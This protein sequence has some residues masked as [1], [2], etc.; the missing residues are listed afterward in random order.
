MPMMRF[1]S[2]GFGASS[3]ETRTLAYAEDVADPYTT[4]GF[5]D[6]M[7]N[8][9]DVTLTSAD[10][11]K[12]II[13]S[14]GGKNIIKCSIT[15]PSAK[16]SNGQCIRIA[17]TDVSTIR[18]FNIIDPDGTNIF[19]NV[20]HTNLNYISTLPTSTCS[21]TGARS[22]CI[23]AT[24]TGM[25]IDMYSNGSIWMV[26]IM[27]A[28]SIDNLIQL[29]VHAFGT[30]ATTPACLLYRC[31]MT[32]TMGGT[33]RRAYMHRFMST[34]VQTMKDCI[35]TAV[36]PESTIVVSYYGGNADDVG[37]SSSLAFYFNIGIVLEDEDDEAEA[38]EDIMAAGTTTDIKTQVN[39]LFG[40]GGGFEAD[41][42]TNPIFSML[43]V[44][45]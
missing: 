14:A 10:L 24:G 23:G 12:M 31:I 11:G 26:Y 7:T 45:Y 29:S 32:T 37:S 4:T 20:K 8:I 1:R 35:D 19:G 18:T 6:Y 38:D 43:I 3:F 27:G 13:V 2:Y 5:T 21:A 36:V 28:N 9:G 25:T 41:G 16:E 40:A 42:L 17:V 39:G 15:L 33:L 22:I 44:Q 34:I 30:Q